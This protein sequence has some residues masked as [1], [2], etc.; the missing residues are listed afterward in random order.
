MTKLEKTTDIHELA[1][2]RA[3]KNIIVKEKLGEPIDTTWLINGSISI[4]ND[5]GEANF[6][7]PISGPNEK[8]T[9]HVIAVKIDGEWVYE[10]LYVIIRDSEERINLL[11]QSLEGI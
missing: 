10:D 7:V 2:E 4:K 3:R 11:D 1:V 8:G 5:T 9:L 6:T